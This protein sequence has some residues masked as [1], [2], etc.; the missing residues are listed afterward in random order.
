M[1]ITENTWFEKGDQ[2][3]RKREYD[4]ALAA[5]Q[6]ALQLEPKNAII[7]NRIGMCQFRC[8]NFDKAIQSFQEAYNI[9]P[10]NVNYWNNIGICHIERKDFKEAEKLFRKLITQFPEFAVGWNNFGTCL[11]NRNDLASAIQA[12]EKAVAL[13]PKFGTAWDTLGSYYEEVDDYHSAL[14][15][16]ISAAEN[17][18]ENSQIHYTISKLYVKT[19]EYDEAFAYLIKAL[20]LEPREEYKATLNELFTLRPPQPDQVNAYDFIRNFNFKKLIL[21]NK[22]ITLI[23]QIYGLTDFKFVLEYLDLSYNKI[24]KMSG[25]EQLMNLKILMLE[26]NQITEIEGLDNLF[27]LQKCSLASNKI[28]ERRG[29]ALLKDLLFINLLDNPIIESKPIPKN[30]IHDQLFPKKTEVPKERF[31]LLLPFNLLYEIPK[32]LQS[33]LQRN[34]PNHC[35]YCKHPIPEGRNAQNTVSSSLQ[36]IINETNSR[37]PS[38]ALGK[39]KY[40]APKK[41]M[42]Y[43]HSTKTQEAVFVSQHY[44]EEESVATFQF[45]EFPPL[46]GTICEECAQAFLKSAELYLKKVKSHKKKD[47]IYDSMEKSYEGYT[48]LLEQWI[49]KAEKQ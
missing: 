8:N 11:Y 1:I 36:K 31:G 4:N 17:F 12:A 33:L 15:A 21:T 46:V 37:I 18:P 10:D 9:E 22:G 38:Q 20:T 49:V 43:N 7:F 26:H 32:K 6:K 3:F 25:L 34:D 29:Y 5:Y 42:R 35:L 45:E 39:V 19:E 44:R 16:Y 23:E 2:Y 41:E 14:K 27:K 47:K 48:R 13:N 24:E 28:T 40:T 30:L